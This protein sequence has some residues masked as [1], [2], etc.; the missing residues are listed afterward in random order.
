MTRTTQIIEL[1]KFKNYAYIRT[2]PIK[3]LHG[4]KKNTIH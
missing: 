2:S 1:N 3:E 4:K